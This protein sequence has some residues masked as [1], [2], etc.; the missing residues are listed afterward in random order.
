M[1]HDI[2]K[3]LDTSPWDRSNHPLVHDY[4]NLDLTQQ[5]DLLFESDLVWRQKKKEHVFARVLLFKQFILLLTRQNPG[6]SSQ[7][8]TAIEVA[9][10]TI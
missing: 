9:L 7:Q 6:P 2:M 8:A 1:L 3:R 5:G 4:K 10:L